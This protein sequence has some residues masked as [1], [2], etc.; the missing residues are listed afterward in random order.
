MAET[1]ARRSGQDRRPREGAWVGRLTEKY[2]Q[3]ATP[4]LSGSA[5][6]THARSVQM[7]RATR[8]RS[9][10]RMSPQ[11]VRSGNHPTVAKLEHLVTGRGHL[12]VVGSEDHGT[13]L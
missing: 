10:G 12:G 3:P 6:D 1:E 13:A 4:E 2:V 11:V 8:T 7:T 5:R 9:S